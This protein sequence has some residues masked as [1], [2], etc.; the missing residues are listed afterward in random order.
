M[1]VD[2]S[3]RQALV[4]VPAQGVGRAPLAVV[5]VFHGFGDTAELVEDQ[6]GFSTKADAAG[7]VAV[8]PQGHGD[9]PR[10]DVAG[11]T[12]TEFIDSL[13]DLLEDDAC[14]DPTRMYASGMSM[15]GGMVNAL[16]CRLAAR[17]AAVAPVSGLYGPGWEGSCTP[18]RPMP[19]IA[20]HGVVDPIVHYAG[21]PIT[22]PQGRPLDDPPTVGIESWA[23][24]WAG[25]NQCDPHPQAQP[26]I[27]QVVPLAWQH[28]V[29]PVV[30]YRIE[31]GGHTW[32]GSAWEDSQTNRDIV[33]TDLI[34]D[35]FSAQV[36]PGS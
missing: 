2:G 26:S 32:P 14:V 13:L 5:L 28:C 4:H 29:A 33:A 7:F 3:P 25:R 36:L 24:G 27:G 20:F 10:W 17:I 8:Y 34:W 30:L 31:D 16:G 21:G 22:D 9:P 1:V 35:F 15:G 12:D 19:L 6:T 23:E 18:A 11:S